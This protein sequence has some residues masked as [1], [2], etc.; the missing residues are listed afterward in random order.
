MCRWACFVFLAALPFAAFPQNKPPLAASKA[1]SIAAG[2]VATDDSG[3]SRLPVKRVVLYKNGIGYFEHTARVHG[4]QDL[5][6]DFTSGQLNDVLKSLTVVDL[7]QGRIGSVRYNSI[8]PL[9]ERLRSLRLPFGE[10]VN[11]AEFL[12]A[13]RGARVDVRSGTSSASGR[14]L[15]VEKERKEK[16]KG[17]F[18][19]VTTFALMTDS[20]EM[21]N[22]ELGPATSV[23]IADRELNDEVGRYLNLVGSSRARDLRRMTIS[24]LGAGEREVFVSYISEVPVWKS[25]YRIILPAKPSEKPLLQGWAIVDNTVGEDWKDVELSLIAGA[26]Q[27]FIQNISQPYYTRRPTVALPEAY[28]LTPQ[29]HE[30]ALNGRNMNGLAELAPGVGSGSGGGVGLR[31]GTGGLQGVIKDQ[32]GAV[33]AGATVTVRNEDSG[34]SQSTTTDARGIYR[35]YNL[36][37]GNSAIFVSANGFKR[38]DFSNVYLGVGRMNE[39]NAALEVGAAATTVEVQ[40]EAAAQVETSSAMIGTIASNQ[41]VEAESKDIGDYFEYDLKQKITISKNQSALVPILSTPVEAEKVSIWN[42][43]EKDVRRALWLKNTSGL[44]V[45]AGTFSILEADTFAGEGI[46]D[47][48]HPDERRLISYAAD[49]ALHIKMEEDGGERPVSHLRIAKGVMV[50]THEQE[51]VRKYTVHNAD[52]APR[53]LVIEHPARDGWKLADTS[54]KA[55]ETTASFLRFRL[56]IAPQSTETLQLEEFHPEDTSYELDNI[57]DNQIALLVQNKSL[58]PSAM[59]ALQRVRD[60]KSQVDALDNQISTRKKE[61]DSISKDQGRVRENMKA[62]KGSSEEKALVQRYAK[63]LNQQEDRLDTLQKELDDLQEKRDKA[64]DDLDQLIQSITLDEHM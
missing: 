30:L 53:S 7:G 47:A 39:I 2:S 38:F 33:V 16:S 26:P 64:E 24:A 21:R 17:E 50:L 1:K 43:E 45:D 11:R 9:D 5:S 57:E 52:E 46:L 19:D 49:P 59:Q 6:I 13:L 56:H 44:T 8:A 34:Q 51:E 61:V 63:Q 54:P 28:V 42:E 41:R 27:S 32:S 15:S 14:L 23:R 18:E 25:T 37:P 29:T 3:T 20:G 62:L 35:F 58:T 48:L 40:G 10:Q 55:E 4:N 36:P 22:F 31:P 12:T 60:Q